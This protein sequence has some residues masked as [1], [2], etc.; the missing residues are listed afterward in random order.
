MCRDLTLDFE[1]WA[2]SAPG[3][4]TSALA[5]WGGAARPSSFHQPKN[6]SSRPKRQTVSSFVAQWRDPR[7]SSL[8]LL[9]FGSPEPA[10]MY[11]NS[12]RSNRH[13]THSTSNAKPGAPYL[14]FEM[15]VSSAA[16]PSSSTNQRNVIFDRSYR[17]GK[18]QTVSSF[19][20]QWRDPR[21]SSLLLL[22]FGS[23]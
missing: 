1:M 13:E 19:V 12:D 4:P 6:S 8:L 18:R 2:S 15:W 5:R 11:L 9:V 22:F 3:P 17:G 10:R 16:R 7:I 14:D 20:A 21:I 23:T